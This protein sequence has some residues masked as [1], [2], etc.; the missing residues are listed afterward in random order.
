[1]N[2][3]LLYFPDEELE[4]EEVNEQSKSESI[5]NSKF[6]DIKGLNKK[7]ISQLSALGYE[8]MT[9]VQEIVIPKIL[10]GGDI[11]FRA[12]TGTGKTLSFL[13]PT[14]QRSLLNEIE[15]TTIS[16]SDGT[17]ILILTP[18]RELCIQTVE[19]ARLI[20][21]KMPWC[22]T[23]CICGGEKRKSEKARLRKGITILGG[24]PGR[25]LDHIDSTNCFKVTNLRTLIVDE[26]DRLLEEGFGASYK[27]IYQ[28]IMN[29]DANSNVCGLYNEDDD[30]EL[31]MLLNVKVNKEKRF[32]KINKQIILVSATLSKPV[33]D[34]ARYS[35]KNNPEWLILD[36]YKEI[37]HKKSDGELEIVQDALEGSQNIPSKG[38]FSVPIN[39][40]QEY[41]VVQDKFRIPALISLLLS[42]TGNGKRTVLF[43]SSTQVVEFYFALLQSM[44]WPS[45]LLIRGG[46]DVK[47]SIKLLENF[48][49][50]IDNKDLRNETENG[51]IHNKFKMNKKKRFNDY[52][53]ES[54]SDL[55]SEIMISDSDSEFESRRKDKKRSDNNN[56][57][58]GHKK[59]FTNNSQLIEKFESM[60]DNYIFKNSIFDD[61][62][63]DKESSNIIG[64][65]KH[66]HISDEMVSNNENITQPPIF[67]LHGHMNK[68]DRLGQLSSFEKSKKGGVIITSDVAS[69]GLNF[70]KI[71]TVIQFDPPQSIEEYVHRMGRTA[72]MGDK[73]TGIIFL[74]PSEE[75][76][77]ETLKSYDIT[78]KNG[79]IKLSDTTIWE[80]LISNN[81][82]SGKIDDISGFF[83]SIINKI[84]TLDPNDS[85]NELLNKARRAY[86]AY[87]RSYMSYDREFSK[88][89]SIKKLH[90]G[91]V[92]SSFGINE[93]PNKI[94]GHIKYLDGI[95]SHKDKMNIN[96]KMNSNKK[97]KIG[98]IEN[99]KRTVRVINK[100][101]N[102]VNK[103]TSIRKKNENKSNFKDFNLKSDSS[104]S[105]IIDKALQ[106]MKS[107]SEIHVER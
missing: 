105:E 38:L 18:T 93:Q 48:K 45:K 67:M 25:I 8:K 12:P 103:G 58:K 29:K 94:I 26:A 55:D 57:L 54:D 21:Q 69:R 64:E 14:I 79:I 74:R 66:F 2:E 46:P 35:L 68:D 101:I 85:H 87:V 99:S 97:N 17:V 47:N 32:D 75:G 102:K 78:G 70:P 7:L 107:K 41:V 34:L 11:L 49:K 73:G 81:S 98:I 80:G 104:K 100:P 83:Y 60:F 95:I 22:V 27:K 88:I 90:L 44:R 33:E 37:G 52:D 106:L 76:Y 23:G 96:S 62:V 15:K 63:E 40:R 13:V 92:A 4:E 19:T 91:H 16:R 24:T 39:L 84:I 6:S 30:E 3:S 72:R 31:S 65:N 61:E 89:F 9:K 77:L 5:Y 53:N 1:M 71:D 86:I 43:V 20:V 56:F 42:R 51:K 36:Q 28:F 82:N 10:N 59:W 50:E